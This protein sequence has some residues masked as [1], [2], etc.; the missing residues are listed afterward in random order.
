MLE[1]LAGFRGLSKTCN[2]SRHTSQ[3]TGGYS[4]NSFPG[5]EAAKETGL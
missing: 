1:I 4:T 3:T 5:P 2:L